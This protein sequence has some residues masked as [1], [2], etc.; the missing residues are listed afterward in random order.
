MPQ[1]FPQGI[2][3]HG[4]Y[5]VSRIT[6]TRLYILARPVL[7]VVGAELLRQGQL[8]LAHRYASS[9]T[10]LGQC[11][12]QLWVAFVR[13]DLAHVR[14]LAGRVALLGGEVVI[15]LISRHLLERLAAAPDAISNDGVA[16]I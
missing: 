7:A 8:F 14:F 1:I 16:F 12:T 5:L 10:R 9:Y 13:G 6:Q 2:I 11:A 3:F 15:I 4:Q